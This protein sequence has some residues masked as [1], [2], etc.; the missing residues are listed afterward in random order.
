MD[1]AGLARF[2]GRAAEDISPGDRRGAS[3]RIVGDR[4]I[5]RLNRR[6]RRKD[7][8]TDVLAFP[9]DAAPDDPWP[10]EE[11]R[12]LGDLVISIETAVRQAEENGHPLDAELRL[13]ALHG[14]LHLFGY[15]HERDRGEMN[16]LEQLLRLRHG[17]MSP[18]AAVSGPSGAS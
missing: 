1:E 14:L 16:R 18:P 15:D 5:R 13:L 3:L 6:Y 2:L 4:T 7:G 9:A 8:P 11:P 12:Y 17:L 10:E